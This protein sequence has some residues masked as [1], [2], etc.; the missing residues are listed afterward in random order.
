MSAKGIGAIT[1]FVIG[2]LLCVVIFMVCNKNGKMKSEY[3]ERQNVIRGKGYKYGFY[4]AM[5]YFAFMAIWPLTE[6]EL[7]LSITV[8]AFVGIVL[9]VLVMSV[10]SIWNDA[11]WAINNNVERYTIMFIVITIFNLFVGGMSIAKGHM[12]KDGKLQD[13]FINL[14]C[15][16]MFLII[17]VVLIVKKYTKK[18]DAEYGE[19]S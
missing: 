12:F 3:D 18:E 11:Y 9:S 15:G 14:L 7:P 10:Y 5:F 4:T 2:L 16:I 19:E 13:P 1:G 17:A 8:E 6:I